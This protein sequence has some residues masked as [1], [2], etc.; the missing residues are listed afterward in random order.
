MKDRFHWT[1]I[2]RDRPRAEDLLKRLKLWSVPVDT[3]A[4]ATAMGIEAYRGDLGE[5]QGRLVV[6]HDTAKIIIRHGDIISRS[7]FVVAHEIGYL[8]QYNRS[9]GPVWTHDDT[10]FKD[11]VD[12][13]SRREWHANCYAAGLVMPIG[14]VSIHARALG[15]NVEKTAKAFEVSA[16]AMRNRFK[17]LRGCNDGWNWE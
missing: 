17:R 11:K 15:Y 5:S 1:K 8:L 14:L 2:A 7:R 10:S 9:N 3:I 12:T 4:V 6:E 13:G 16:D